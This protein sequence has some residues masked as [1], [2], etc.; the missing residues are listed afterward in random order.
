MS[1]PD[2]DSTSIT[3]LFH[4]VCEA[5]ECAPRSPGLS[6]RI[7]LSGTRGVETAW[8]VCFLGWD[9]LC[10]SGSALSTR[11]ELGGLEYCGRGFLSHGQQACHFVIICLLT[12]KSGQ[13]RCKGMKN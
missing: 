3:G 10:L 5:F 1:R 12:G 4:V 13:F 11:G 6:P 8:P 9:L 7:S 2:G